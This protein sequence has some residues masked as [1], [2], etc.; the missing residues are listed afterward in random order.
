MSTPTM[1]EIEP[2]LTTAQL[3]PMLAGAKS[4]PDLEAALRCVPVHPDKMTQA[5]ARFDFSAPEAEDQAL[6]WALAESG[7]SAPVADEYVA[8]LHR[9]CALKHETRA[10]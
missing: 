9:F 10:H 7:I 8:A 4:L 2:P 1:I 6:R 5:L 3:V